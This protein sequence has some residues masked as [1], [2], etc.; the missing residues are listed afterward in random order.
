ML[1]RNLTLSLAASEVDLL[2][3][4]VTQRPVGRWRPHRDVVR[5]RVAERIPVPNEGFPAREQRQ[6]RAP[7]DKDCIVGP[8][9]QGSEPLPYRRIAGCGVDF[10]YIIRL[11]LVRASADCLVRDGSG[12]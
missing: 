11:Y 9:V 4:P 5:R 7:A 12:G 8:N 3:V 2:E 10:D 6:A 1:C